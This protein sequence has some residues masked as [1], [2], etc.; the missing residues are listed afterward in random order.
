MRY[1]WTKVIGIAAIAV[2]IFGYQVNA[3]SLSIARSTLADREQALKEQNFHK[4]GEYFG[5][6]EGYQ[7]PLSVRVLVEGGRISEIEIVETKDDPA[8]VVTTQTMID[9]IIKQ[10][11]TDGVDTVSGATYSSTGIL[12]AVKSALEGA[13]L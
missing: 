1:F 5:T 4:D 8:Y 2:I 11:T 7:G 3:R 12:N 13:G 10:Q 6:A 9:E